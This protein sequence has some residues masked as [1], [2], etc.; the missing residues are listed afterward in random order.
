MTT[1]LLDTNIV[2]YLFK[3]D[4]RAALCAPHLLHRELAIAMMTVA[5]LFQWAAIRNWGEPRV[6]R[7][8]QR[9]ERYTILPVDLDGCRQWA[10]VRATRSKA[11]LPISP[12]DAWIAATARRYHLALVTHNPD[13]YQQIPGLTIITEA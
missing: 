2:S 11:G 10:E 3:R 12:Q 9:F 4:S 13:D 8:E 7:L 6:R 5:E 1:V